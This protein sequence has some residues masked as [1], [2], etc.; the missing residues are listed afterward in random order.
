MAAWELPVEV[1]SWVL[2]MSCVLDRRIAWRLLPLL[3]G[4]LFG[5]GRWRAKQ[6]RRELPATDAATGP[7]GGGQQRRNELVR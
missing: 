2:Q 4:A 3:V 6:P 5:Q 1:A 7:A